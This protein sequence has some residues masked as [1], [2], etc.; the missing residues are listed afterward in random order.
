[1]N[2]ITVLVSGL[3]SAAGLQLGN[4]K[5][6]LTQFERAIN[7]ANIQAIKVSLSKVISMF[8]NMIKKEKQ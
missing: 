1:M 2:V 4:I 8:E 3:L 6:E 7:T 5:P